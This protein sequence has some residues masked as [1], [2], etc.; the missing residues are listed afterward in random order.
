MLK[1]IYFDEKVKMLG[2]NIRIIRQIKGVSQEAIAVKLNISQAAYSKMENGIISLSAERLMIILNE[3]N[4]S[5]KTLREP[6]MKNVLK[7]D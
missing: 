6:D 3:L 5:E 1:S 2:D 7:S 4:V